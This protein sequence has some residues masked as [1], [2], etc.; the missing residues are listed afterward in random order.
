MRC[1][2]R[3]GVTW[4]AEAKRLEGVPVACSEAATHR[5]A[6]AGEAFRGA[7]VDVCRRHA[8]AFEGWAGRMTRVEAT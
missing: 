8:H 5:Y 2:L 6:F 3:D 7:A 4:N 1:E